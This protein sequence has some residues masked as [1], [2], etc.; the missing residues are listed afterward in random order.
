MFSGTAAPVKVAPMPAHAD[1]P[2]CEGVSRGS[3][4]QSRSLGN[5]RVE[6]AIASLV[7][8]AAHQ[9]LAN[10]IDG[11]AAGNVAGQRAAHSI[12]DHQDQAFFAQIKTGEIRWSSPSD[13]VQVFSLDNSRT[14]KLSSLPRRTL[15]TSDFACSSTC[16]LGERNY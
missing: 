10:R 11:H 12:G 7:A 15:P 1:L 16:I 5:R 13:P 2:G 9:H 3:H 8:V 4:R 14:R 6:F